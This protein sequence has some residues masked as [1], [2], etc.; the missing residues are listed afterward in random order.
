MLRRGYSGVKRHRKVHHFQASKS[1]PPI[2]TE[3]G[4][5]RSGEVA[6]RRSLSG[7]RDAGAA[8]AQA[9]ALAFEGDHG[10]VVDEPVDQGGGDDGVAEDLA[11]LLEAA[12][13]G[14][15]DR[16]ALV[17]AGDQGEERVGGLAL[18]GE[19]ADLVDDEQVV[20]REPAQLLLELVAVLR[21]LEAADPLLGGREGDPV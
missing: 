15:G 2:W 1:A 6:E 17:A 21:G 14:D 19:V 18:Q 5:R 11:P 20:A 3:G 4:S 9:V 12:V 10:G 13:R 16:A 7:G 8:F